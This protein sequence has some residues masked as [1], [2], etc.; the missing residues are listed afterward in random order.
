[1][2]NGRA[3]P[4]GMLAASPDDWLIEISIAQEADRINLERARIRDRA[5]A[6]MIAG[7]TIRNLV[8]ALRGLLR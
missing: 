4:L 3:D 6:E 7:F 5:L 2:L 8:R 1:M